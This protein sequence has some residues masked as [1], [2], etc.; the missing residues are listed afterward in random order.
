[1]K[2]GTPT[3]AS[4]SHLS[5]RLPSRVGAPELDG[6]RRHAREHRSEQ[7]QVADEREDLDGERRRPEG[8]RQVLQ[9]RQVRIGADGAVEMVRGGAQHQQQR[10][11]APAAARQ[12]PVGEV[13]QQQADRREEP[14][15]GLRR[16]GDQPVQ[17]LGRVV[18]L[19]EDLE[20]DLTGAAEGHA[21]TDG[22][23]QRADRVVAHPARDEALRDRRTPA[24][25]H[26]RPPPS[27]TSTP[28]APA[29]RGRRRRRPARRSPPS[30][31]ARRAT[32]ISSPANSRPRRDPADRCQHG[33]EDPCQWRWQRPQAVRTLDAPSPPT[34][35]E[36]VD[37]RRH[38]RH[39]ERRHPPRAMRRRGRRAA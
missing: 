25:P 12:P 18:V 13:H 1:M 14:R 10:H 15:A 17:A 33:T 9:R 23:E 3:P 26:R 7:R 20:A 19:R 24:P 11:D 38:A 39:R 28:S 29:W 31:R 6:D 32:A 37:V 2:P 22:D 8:V 35:G 30:R 34:A 5:C 16:Q 21:R 4:A 27:R 36:A